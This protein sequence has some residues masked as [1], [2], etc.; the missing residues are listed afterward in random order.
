MARMKTKLPFMACFFMAITQ[1]QKAICHLKRGI[2][3]YSK[4]VHK[5]KKFEIVGYIIKAIAYL[6]SHH[7]DTI[8][9]ETLI[10]E[11]PNEM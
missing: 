4:K 6:T 2:E 7:E 3:S 1:K 10:L 8:I 11:I 9:D 5:D